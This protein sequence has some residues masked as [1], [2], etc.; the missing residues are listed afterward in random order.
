[1]AGA[2]AGYLAPMSDLENT[3]IRDVEEQAGPPEIE[4]LPEEEGVEGTDV[5]ERL[6]EDPEDE[7]INRRDV[8]DTSESSA[9][10]RTTD[11]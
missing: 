1:M 7:S 5:E 9:E 4:G 10:V 3:R 2:A 11:E 8:P 6:E